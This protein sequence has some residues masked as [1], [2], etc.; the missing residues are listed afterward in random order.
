MSAVMTAFP[1]KR[2]WADPL[3]LKYALLWAVFSSLGVVLCDQDFVQ[4]NTALT[5][6][7]VIQDSKYSVSQM[8]VES[9]RLK[10][11]RI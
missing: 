5:R 2:P 11:V 4:K 10:A 6:R 1:K 8:L 9:A 7:V 3:A